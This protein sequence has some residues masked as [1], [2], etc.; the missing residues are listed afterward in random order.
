[1]KTSIVMMLLASIAFAQQPPKTSETIEVTATKIA[2]DVTVVPAA[3]TVIDGD[4]LRARNARDLQTALG[5]TAGVS[6]SPGGDQG[7]A[8]VVPELWGLREF[9]AFLLV[10]DGVP[11]GGAFN[12][13][14]Q[15]LDLENV[16]RIEVVRGAAPVMY[17]ATSFVGVIHVIHRVAGA[18]GKS[19]RVSAGTYGTFGLAVS[20]PSITVSYDKHGYDEQRTEWQ[21]A[22]LLYRA[23]S[24]VSG[25]TLRV[26]VDGTVLW[27]DPSS[28]HPRQG[29]VLSPL[30]PVGANHNPGGA[31]MDQTRLHGVIGFEKHDWTTTLAL[32][33]SDFDI[34]RGF[35]L[36]VNE[37]NPN[38]A[39]YFQDRGVTDVYFDTHV[40]RQWKP[41]VRVIAGFDHLYGNARA[42]SQL[43]DYF[44]HL[45]GSGAEDIGDVN[46]DDF[47]EVHDHRNFSGLYVNSE[48]TPMPRLRVDVGAR[49]NHTSEKRETD[50]G[51]E[52]LTRTRLSGIVGADWQ[53][54]T[55]GS[56]TLAVFADYRNAF[57]PAAIDFG[58]ES[59]ADI[60]DP[61]TANSVEAGVKG[62]LLDGRARWQLSAFKMN[63][64]N[65]VVATVVNGLPALDNVGAIK[66]HGVEY[67]MD[68]ALQPETRIEFGYSY[69]DN[70]FGDY[71][72]AFDGVPTQLRGRRFEMSPF[73]LLGA[74]A[75]Y[76]PATGFNA[77]LMLNYT[78]EQFLNK[79]NTALADAYTAWN[80]GVG[81]R[82]GRNEIRVDGRNLG[83]TRPPVA[84]S[85]LGD[86][87]YYRMP[88]RSLEVSYR[89]N[90]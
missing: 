6:I 25:G 43:F 83:N 15:T 19:A 27:Q 80:A 18:Q 8:G 3:V 9:D 28:P 70:R 87:Q 76:T 82:R 21:R 74:G 2:E 88:A 85:E 34:A 90:W 52:S 53:I 36:G 46:P 66:V 54:W 22:H 38:A 13:D 77:N 72:Q 11:W 32:T 31:K 10:V 89:M 14:T 68:F 35:L 30:I 59:E 64:K 17:G 12:P 47:P 41:N 29:A 24:G 33:R 65:L 86:A 78:G 69:H 58:P 20:L 60:L 55:H 51:S 61:E 67:E 1:M 45:N 4:E 44:V 56:D 23:A 50:E 79:R 42:Q 63:M 84:E 37:N 16:D 49:L 40:V 75:S 48:W 26:D 71:V 73:H 62:R 5:F 7:P 81:Y 39:G 57:K